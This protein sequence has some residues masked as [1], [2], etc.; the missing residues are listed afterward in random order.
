VGKVLL[1]NDIEGGFGDSDQLTV[2]SS[3]LNTIS[4]KSG[5]SLGHIGV[6]N[7]DLVRFKDG[8]M[9][10][11]IMDAEN[12]TCFQGLKPLPEIT[13]EIKKVVFIEGSKY[14]GRYDV[15]GISDLGDVFLIETHMGR[16][17]LFMRA[18]VA[19]H[20]LSDEEISFETLVKLGFMSQKEL[21]ELYSERREYNQLSKQI[22]QWEK[23]RLDLQ[24][25][26]LGKG[27][28]ESNKIYGKIK[29]LEKEIAKTKKRLYGEWKWLGKKR[30][31]FADLEGNPKL[32][33]PS[34]WQG[35]AI[36]DILD[37]K[38][39]ERYRSERMSGHFL[40]FKD[41]SISTP[42]LCIWGKGNW[43]HYNTDG[44]IKAEI[45]TESNKKQMVKNFNI[46]LTNCKIRQAEDRK[47]WREE[48]QQRKKEEAEKRRIAALPNEI[49]ELRTKLNDFGLSYLRTVGI[50][51][52]IREIE[53]EIEAHQKSECKL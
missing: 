14:S 49:R 45:L 11:Q 34:A 6:S 44:L 36:K 40:F 16:S 42:I 51:K 7:G 52:K 26:M 18:G 37:V 21:E 39:P 29:D 15:E 28:L 8:R 1:F 53:Q 17:Q 12:I 5:C 4:E 2:A 46:E 13:G 9:E 33:P 50:L 35:R 30:V 38:L 22:E 27:L 41:G 20:S 19:I 31:S 48:D 23:E 10:L 3:G 24:P 47:R 43:I 32:V 25:Q